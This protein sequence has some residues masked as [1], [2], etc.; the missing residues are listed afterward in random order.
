MTVPD[1]PW[2]GQQ[3]RRD[4]SGLAGTRRSNQDGAGRL[5]QSSEQ[6]GQ[7]RMDGEPGTAPVSGRTNRSIPPRHRELC[8]FDHRRLGRA[9][10]ETRDGID[11]AIGEVASAVAGGAD[12]VV[13]ADQPD[14]FGQIVFG[15]AVARNGV[16]PELAF[17]G[18]S[19]RA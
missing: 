13:A 19:P 1:A 10:R 3:R 7:D 12:G 14:R 15:S 4:R 6:L 2:L 17:V 5:A 8:R 11:R 16:A 9:R 18:S